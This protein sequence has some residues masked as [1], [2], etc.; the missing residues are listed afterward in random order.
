MKFLRGLHGFTR[1]FFQHSLE[2]LE[3]LSKCLGLDSIGILPDGQ[4]TACAWAIDSD[5]RPLKKARLGKLPEDDLDEIMDNARK[6]S[7]YF[8]KTKF[9]RT[10]AYIGEDI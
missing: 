3:N 8:K 10:I 5:C 9:C 2:M 4:V 7:E 6:S 1:I